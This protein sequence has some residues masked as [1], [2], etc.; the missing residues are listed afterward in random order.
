MHT[1]SSYIKPNLI[2]IILLK[3]IS[4]ILLYIL[5]LMYFFLYIYISTYFLHYL[6]LY[7][8]LYLPVHE[9]EEYY[10][11]KNK[12]LFFTSKSIFHFL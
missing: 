6:L 2:I 5:L 3:F 9:I 4:N 8:H 10:S 7:F 11:G 12:N 1:Y